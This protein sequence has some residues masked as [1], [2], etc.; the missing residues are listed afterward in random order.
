M[1]ILEFVAFLISTLISKSYI[2]SNFNYSSLPSHFQ[3]KKNL[4]DSRINS[5]TY[6]YIAKENNYISKYSAFNIN[7]KQYF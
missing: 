3:V 1:Q 6:S 4:S 5:F 2:Y 7:V